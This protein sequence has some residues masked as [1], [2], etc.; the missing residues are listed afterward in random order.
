[1]D[2]FL[3][4]TGRFTYDEKTEPSLTLRR[5]RLLVSVRSVAEAAAALEGG[6]D[7]IDIKEPARGPLGRADDSTIGD[8]VRFVA[9][10]RPVSAA[11]GELTDRPAIPDHG[12]AYV[13]WGLAGCRKGMDWRNILANML[14]ALTPSMRPVVVG[15]ADWACAGAPALDDV[16]GFAREWPGAGILID[17]YDK[18]HHAQGERFTLLDWLSAPSI[19]RICR[20]CRAAGLPIALAGSL[21]PEDIAVLKEAA[22]DWFAVRGAACENGDRA[23]VVNASRVQALV[24]LL[25]GFSRG[26]GI[27]AT[28]T[29][30]LQSPRSSPDGRYK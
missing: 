22:P 5:A 27:A 13:K 1:L 24:E 25:G 26:M 17:T 9:G 2:A 29:T 16:V 28:Q 11:L 14:Q 12:L 20:Q 30:V 19:V 3:S 8:I 10:R 21:R 7:L 18:G 23:A 4:G 15:Y 6:A